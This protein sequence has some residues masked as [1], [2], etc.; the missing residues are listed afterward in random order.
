MRPVSRWVIITFALFIDL[1][2]NTI[3]VEF[4][5]RKLYIESFPN[6]FT[7]FQILWR[8]LMDPI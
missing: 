6:S 1:F 3:E 7:A 5:S 8:A 2:E 4:C